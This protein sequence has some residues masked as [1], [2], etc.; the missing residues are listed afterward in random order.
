LVRTPSGKFGAGHQQV[1]NL[2]LPDTAT[3]GGGISEPGANNSGYGNPINCDAQNL[4]AGAI[5][6]GRVQDVFMAE[7]SEVLMSLTKNW[8]S[9]DSS[10][11]GLSQFTSIIRFQTGHYAYYG[12][13]VE[14][15]LNGTGSAIV[16]NQGT[17]S[18]NAARSDWVNTTFTGVTVSGV[19]VHG[20]GDPVSFG[21]A[22]AF[23]FYLNTQLSFS[24][25]NI[26]SDYAG[27]L[28]SAYNTLTGDPGNP[29]PF[30][31]ALI[32]NVY[33]ASATATIPGPV[34]DNPFPL[35]ECGEFCKFL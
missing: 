28:T 14:N 32:D 1:V 30:F 8:N 3:G 20:D 7:W 2:N 10:G 24:I 27:T 15:W 23:I 13:F 22:L 11:E 5:A 33:P 29:F 21:C 6:A 35:V 26:I 16:T 18:P 34:T 25:N 31:M 17:V 9:G 12:S 19:F 4:V